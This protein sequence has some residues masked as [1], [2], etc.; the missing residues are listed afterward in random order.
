MNTSRQEAVSNHSPSW[1]P[2]QT[3]NFAT[4]CI[5]FL[6]LLYILEQEYGNVASIWF[7]QTF[8]K[9]AYTLGLI[10]RRPE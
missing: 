3:L 2:H 6:V 10:N 4:Y 5:M 9:E 7:I 8:P 1:T